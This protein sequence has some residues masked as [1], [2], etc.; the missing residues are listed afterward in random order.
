MEKKK[1]ENIARVTGSC[2]EITR[3]LAYQRLFEKHVL[4]FMAHVI[5]HQTQ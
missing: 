1:R 5:K 2:S 3:L 4:L